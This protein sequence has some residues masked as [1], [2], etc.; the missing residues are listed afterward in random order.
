MVLT[1]S[2]M[3]PLGTDMPVFEIENP[4]TR[5]LARSEDLT[6]EKGTV[7]AFLCNHC[8]YVLHIMPTLA[9]VAAEL[10]ARGVAFIGINANDAVA[11]PDDAPAKMP[12]FMAQYE[13]SFPYLYDE[14]QAVAKAFLAAC[15]PDFFV[16]DADGKLTYRGQFCASRPSGSTPVTGE[17]L[18]AAVQAMLT[19]EEYAPQRPSNG[20]NI[21]WKAA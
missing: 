2:A 14:S 17:D 12:A 16:Y 1:T 20:C 7:V 21:K 6:G 18:Q 13:A 19:G 11:Y 5:K 8:P 3:V 4:I 10:Q 15:T 9:R